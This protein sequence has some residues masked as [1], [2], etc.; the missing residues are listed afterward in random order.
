VSE[1]EIDAKSTWILPTWHRMDH[2]SWSLGVFS[3]TTSWWD[4]HRP[5]MNLGRPQHSEISQP[6]NWY[7]LSCAR[8]P[9]EWEFVEI[10][11]FTLQG[12]E[13]VLGRSLDTSFGCHNLMVTDLGSC[14]KQP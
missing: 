1:C 5:D 3:R 11:N 14:V 7:I 12:F 10:G 6:L 13:S 2:V 9:R 8:T 4:V